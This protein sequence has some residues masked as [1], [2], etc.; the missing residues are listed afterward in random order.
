MLLAEKNFICITDAAFG[1]FT[2]KPKNA[3]AVKRILEPDAFASP[4]QRTNC[5]CFLASEKAGDKGEFKQK[6]AR[7]VP[8]S[9]RA[10]QQE[11]SKDSEPLFPFSGSNL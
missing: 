4:A 10:S 7:R 8:S 6:K 2:H 9:R 11:E 1:T 3:C 5:F